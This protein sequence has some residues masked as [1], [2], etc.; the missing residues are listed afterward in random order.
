MTDGWIKLHRKSLGSSVWTDSTVWFV[1]SWCLFKASYKD[2]KFPFNGTD[3]LLLAGSFVTGLKKATEELN[4]SEAQ[5]RRAVK[6][7][8]STNRITTKSNN[9]FTI[10][11]I[12]NWIAYQIDDKQ[13]SGKEVDQTTSYPKN[14][15]LNTT[16]KDSNDYSI[17]E[18]NSIV[19][20]IRPSVNST[21]QQQTN[22]KPTT[23]YKNIKEIKEIYSNGKDR[24][25]YGARYATPE[26]NL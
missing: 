7:L 18:T 22:N 5:Y 11:T 20:T 26:D 16:G 8:K 14:A 2:Y 10:I 21:N 4:I 19:K 3:I 1:W 6:Y 17:V 24:R 15:P 13:A 12:K 9:K 23:T 25:Y